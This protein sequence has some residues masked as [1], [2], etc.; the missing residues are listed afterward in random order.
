M[1]KMKPVRPGMN[2]GKFIISLDFELFWGMRDERTIE[3]YGGNL[4]GVHQVIP[5]LLTIFNESQVKATFAIVGF[6]FFEKK[7]ELLN[8]LP[9]KQPGYLNKNLSPYSGHFDFVGKDAETDPYHFAPHL[10]RCI[11]NYPEQEIGTHTFSHYY[12]LE[13]GQTKEEFKADI[14]SA[15]KIAGEY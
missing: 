6:L 5:R 8:N 7:V 9:E 11:R 1:K 3:Q 12:C 4:K 14:E 13:E 2:N 15:L 10:I